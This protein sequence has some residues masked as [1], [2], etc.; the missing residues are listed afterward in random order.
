MKGDLKVVGVSVDT[1]PLKK[2]RTYRKVDIHFRDYDSHTLR[3][4]NGKEVVIRVQAMS[5]E[6]ES[7]LLEAD[8]RI[9][10]ETPV[11]LTLRFYPYIE[12]STN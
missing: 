4:S 10:E 5:I 12:K 8:G 1:F 7:L 2:K 9:G 6:A 3:L 11:L